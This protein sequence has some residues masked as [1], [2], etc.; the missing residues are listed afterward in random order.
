MAGFYFYLVSGLW[1]NEN[2]PKRYRY[3]DGN[4]HVTPGPM[5]Q[6]G[7]GYTIAQA[8]TLGRE[9]LDELRLHRQEMERWRADQIVA[10]IK[11]DDVS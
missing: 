1:Q 3:E 2:Y 7:I 6:I 8:L 11:G 9:L 5:K 10:R 4:K